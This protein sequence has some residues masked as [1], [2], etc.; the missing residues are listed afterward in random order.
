[1]RKNLVRRE[2]PSTLIRDP[3]FRNFDRLFSEDLFRP[4]GFLARPDDDLGQTG[5]LPAVG[6]KSVDSS[7]R[8]TPRSLLSSGSG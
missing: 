4:F 5:W 1:M 6:W 7:A 8:S 3:F 2:A